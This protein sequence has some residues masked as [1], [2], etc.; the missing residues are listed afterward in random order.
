M[1]VDNEALRQMERIFSIKNEIVFIYF[2][3]L[4]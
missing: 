4:F 2:G 3:W 1:L